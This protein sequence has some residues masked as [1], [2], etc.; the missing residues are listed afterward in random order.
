MIIN[1]NYFC[2]L[3]SVCQMKFIA[4]IFSFCL[5]VCFILPTKAQTTAQV[6]VV[7]FYNVENLFDTEDDPTT[8]DAEFLPTGS[9]QWTAER[10]EKKLKDLSDVICLIGKEYGGAAILGLSEIENKKVMEDLV[11]TEKLSPFHYGVVH[12]DSPDRR[13]VDVGLIYQKERFQVLQVI[14]H[15]LT[16]PEDTSFRTRD[17][18]LVVGILDKIDTLHILVNHW[19]SKLGGERR[20]L[21]KRVAAAQLSR[22][23]ADSIMAINKNAKI[24]IMGDLNDNPDAKSIIEVLNAKGKMKEVGEGDLFNPMW[25]LYRDGIWSY[26]YQDTPNVIDNVIVSNGLLATQSGYHFSSAHIF[27]AKFM[28]ANSGSYAGYPLR[29]YASGT[30]L[31]GYSDHL[32]VYILL[33][34]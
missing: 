15:R 12:H 18:L 3:I 16:L 8:N 26:V 22:H 24:I 14:P 34:K 28:F 30:Y 6:A 10:Y 20:S 19:P 7:G 29:T 32:P 25:K 5:F 23:I 33:Q 17:Q 4:C 11:A 2:L 9:Y 21:P 13:G 27:R 31:G 1:F